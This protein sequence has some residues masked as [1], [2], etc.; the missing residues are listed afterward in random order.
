MSSPRCQHC[1]DPVHPEN[2][3]PCNPLTLEQL[4]RVYTFDANAWAA[5]STRC[6][7]TKLF[8]APSS[9]YYIILHNRNGGE[10]N[11][12]GR[13]IRGSVPMKYMQISDDDLAQFTPISNKHDL[14]RRIN[15]Y[16]VFGHYY[17]CNGP[18]TDLEHRLVVISQAIAKEEILM[19][20]LRSSSPD[21]FAIDRV[22]LTLS[23]GLLDHHGM[24]NA[25]GCL[26]GPH[27]ALSEIAEQYTKSLA[28]DDAGDG[29]LPVPLWWLALP[30]SDLLARI[31]E[32]AGPIFAQVQEQRGMTDDCQMNFHLKEVREHLGM[33][34][35]NAN[36]NA[37]ANA[38]PVTEQQDFPFSE[39]F[40]KE[41]ALFVLVTVCCYPDATVFSIPGGKRKIL[42]TP[43]EVFARE[44]EEE[45]GVNL[46]PPAVRFRGDP[47]PLPAD[48]DHTWDVQMMLQRT[49]VNLFYVFHKDS[50]EL[51]AAAQQRALTRGAED[52][53]P[54]MP[55]STGATAG[56]SVFRAPQSAANPPASDCDGEVVSLLC[57]NCGRQFNFSVKDQAFYRS[58]D[59]PPPKRCR[60]C[61]TSSR[62]K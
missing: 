2:H 21:A 3:C 58:K 54:L 23:Q 25:G 5:A 31:R 52:Y 4:T 43:W 7:R 50:A 39:F 55:D 40:H 8:Y 59:Y 11:S 9:N 6:I 12:S 29:L 13:Q 62:P 28:Y 14:R 18:Q 30:S 22:Y 47:E 38:I 26:I 34:R 51:V 49:T 45:C 36:A 57:C 17:R 10:Y 15:T 20:K 1:N 53:P 24:D 16:H 32:L 35:A 46:F 19:A 56:G 60:N 44:C 41:S 61:R 27:D 33:W 37:S 42:E 48:S